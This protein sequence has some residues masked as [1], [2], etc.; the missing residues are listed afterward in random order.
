[1]STLAS[2]PLRLSG[3]QPFT[4]Q[5]GS[6][7]L[8]GE[9]TNVAGSPKFAKLIKEGKYEDAVSVARQQVE[10]GANVLDICMDEGMI[11]GVAAMSRYLQ[12]LASEPEVAKVPFMV[13]S[14]KWE[15]IEAGL[16]CLQGKGIV[17]SISLKEGEDK[18]R[19]NARTVLKYGAAVVVMAFDEQGQAATYA[20]KIRICARAYRILVDELRFPPEDIIFDPNILTV[21]TGMEEHNNYAIDFIEATRWIKQNLPHAK[22]SGGVSNISFSFR[23]NNKVREAMH[24]AF[25]YHAIAAGM[26]MG[27]V[28]AGMLEVYEEIEPELKVLVEDVLLNRRPDATERLVEH[29]EKLKNVG[30]AVNEKKAEEW[31]LGTVEERLAHALVRGI[32][33]YIEADAEEARV[34]LGR[35]LLVIEGPL[36]AGMSV[37]GDLFGAGKMFLP[38]VVKSAR[39]MKKAVA[40]LTP[41]MEAEKAAL[42]A[43][44]QEVKAQGKILLATVKGDVHDIGKNIVGVVLACNNFEV[45]DMGVMVSAEKILERAR[46]E[47][48]DIIGLSGLI[49][50]SLDE[51]VHVA[52]EMERGGFK[53]PLL[54]GGATTSRAHTAVK[55]APHYSQPVVHVL[56]ASR[57][58]PVTTSLLSEDG[59]AAFVAQYRTE[60]DGLRKAYAQPRQTA[61]PLAAARARRTPIEWRAEDVPHPGF[62]GVCVLNDFPLATLREYID[63]SPFFHT[64]GMKGIYPRILDDERQGAEARKIF[65]DGQKLLDQ[66]IAEK[67]LT[68]RG[69]YGMFAA[70]AVGDDVEVYTDCARR[71]LLD[72][73]HFLRQQVGRE[74][75]EPCRSLADFIAPK[76]TGLPDH[77]GAFAVTTGVGLKELGDRFRAE[78]DDYNAIMAEALADRLAEAFAECLDERVRNEWGYG[79]E[80]TFTPAELVQEKYRGVRPAPGYPA[81]PDHT[82]KGTI[83]GLLDVEANTGIRITE[84]FAMWPGSSVSGL[85]FAHPQSRYFSLGKIDRDQVADYHLRK[86][87]SV[88]EVERWLGQNLLYDPAPIAVR[89]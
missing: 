18:F 1:M 66:I 60:Y 19:Q 44:G 64:W 45:I 6:F 61:V 25:L 36:M 30:V 38:Q 81:C 89:G 77:L 28:N 7:M 9:R 24:S 59:N 48:V 80:E 67:L 22:V 29:G 4:Q 78:H 76:E 55:I 13:D 88:A 86:G 40:H 57:A 2:K 14:S 21:A 15:V 47:K 41:Y 12:L 34:Q 82:E 17:N 37:V 62:H 3:S 65:D 33:T 5:P 20:E 72:R 75:T 32:D 46:A 56:D 43:S 16:K 35:P 42:L 85:Y 27:I 54:I 83:W 68:A 84:S 71:T 39:V 11:D 69:V 70:N 87:M 58:V 53:Q 10:N 50:P 23:G 73:F 31:R 63:W 49:T 8:L 79:C 26:D 52:R 74:G 51:M